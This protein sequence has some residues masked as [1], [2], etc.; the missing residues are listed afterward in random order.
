M[1]NKKIKIVASVVIFTAIPSLLSYIANSNSAIVRLQ[2]LNIIDKDINT[3][4]I[5]DL[6]LLSSIILSVILLSFN[7]AKSKIKN[8]DIIEQRDLLL[9]LAKDM[10][11]GALKKILSQNCSDFDV[12]IFVPKHP[13]LYRITE[14]LHFNNIKKKFVIKNVSQ[15]A[16]EGLTK[17]LEFQVYPNAQGLVGECYKNKALV[18]D[19]ELNKTNSIN[20]NLDINQITRTSNLEWSICCPICDKDNNVISIIAL[21]GRKKITINAGKKDDLC[22]QVYAFSQMLYDAV[23][24]LFRR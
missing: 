4:L 21:D 23:P 10:F 13:N 6:C 7:L 20:Y 16:Q 5:K 3:G 19:D 22:K 12:R 15:I 1:E 24:T 2:R 14:L 8:E 9:K 18:Y 17:N 11:G